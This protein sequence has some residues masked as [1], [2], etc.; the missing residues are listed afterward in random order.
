MRCLY[1]NKEFEKGSEEHVIHNS[2]GGLLTSDKIC[3]HDFNNM[4]S[5]KI[6]DDF[7]KIFSPSSS[8]L[9]LNKSHGKNSKP[10]HEVLIEY[11]GKIY[12]AIYKGNIF[13]RLFNVKKRIKAKYN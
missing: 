3:C 2:I 7:C 5:K 6:D 8:I 11:E 9:N 4:V 1:C 10:F 13:C 12:T